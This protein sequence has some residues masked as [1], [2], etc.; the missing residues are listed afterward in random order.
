[1]SDFRSV[2]S[3]GELAARLGSEDLVILDT[4]FDLLDPGR[5]SALWLES[6]IP[7]AQY[8]HLDDDLAAP[9][10]ERTGRHPL[11]DAESLARFLAA[12][13]V[14]GDRQVVLYDDVGGA[15]AARGWWLLRWLGHDRA[16]VLDGGFPL[17]VEA[18][19]PVETEEPGPPADNSSAGGDTAPRSDWVVSTDELLRS[20][21]DLRLVDARAAERFR[22][23]SEP[24]DPVRGHVPGASNLPFSELLDDAG[25]F[26]S[27]LRIR[28]RL[29]RHLDG[30]PESPWVAMCGSGV[31]ACHLALAAEYAGLPAPRIYIGSFSEWIR[32][33]GREVATG[34]DQAS[35]DRS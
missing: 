23:E 8:A 9:V 15:I 26:H 2:I 35:A 5:G 24:I 33:P 3:G 6:R 19:L 25:R 22:G 21:P 12:K 32:D 18:G 1:M 34:A 20:L 28:E 30:D 11:P 17:W 31:T 27:P 13:G 14:T 4:R 10:A 7:G 29:T 16:A